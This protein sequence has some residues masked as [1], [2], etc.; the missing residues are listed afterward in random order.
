MRYQ[1]MIVILLL[2]LLLKAQS[3]S[4]TFYKVDS[5]SYAMYANH[6]W[7]KLKLF[8][9]DAIYNGY[10][11]PNLRIRIADADLSLNNSSA[12]L[13]QIRKATKQDS[14]NSYLLQQE[15]VADEMLGRIANAQKIIKHNPEMESLFPSLKK[16]YL[17]SRFEVEGG[18]KLPDIYERENLHYLRLSIESRINRSLELRQ[19]FQHFDQYLF[20][21]NETTG[22]KFSVSQM[23]YYARISWQLNSGWSLRPAYHFISYKSDSISDNDNLFYLGLRKTFPYWHITFSALTNDLDK[24]RRQQFAVNTLFYPFGNTKFYC[25]VGITLRADTLNG[26]VI[27]PDAGLGFSIVKRVWLEAAITPS[28]IGDYAENEGEYIY[29][30]GDRTL[31]KYVFILHGQISSHLEL[32]FSWGYELKEQAVISYNYNQYGIIGGIT[33]KI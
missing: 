1:L 5:T 18:A 3:D 7:K 31:S 11:Y 10:D 22:R 16:R 33:W 2:P 25:W 12:A 14:H 29:N 32:S 26:N 6:Q 9:D 21:T 30:S 28:P 15:I 24:V 8:G 19:S 20:T 27:I 4:L 17:I 13:Q 23:Q